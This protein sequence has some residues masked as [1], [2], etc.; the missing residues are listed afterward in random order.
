MRITRIEGIDVALP[1]AAPLLTC[2]G[3]LAVYPRTLVLVHTD[4]ELVGIG[5]T[6]GLVGAEQIAAFGRML[7]GFDPWELGLVRARIEG[8]GYYVT[9][10]RAMA[11]IE[12]ACLDLMGKS[13]DRPVHSL[14]GGKVRS[15]VPAAAYLFSRTANADGEGA[16]SSPEQILEQARRWGAEYGFDAFK[17]KGG[18]LTPDAD[19]ETLRLLAAELGADVTLR[20]DPQ[21]A[22]S[23]PTAM[24]V[25]RQM[26]ALPMEYLEDPVVGM[27]AMAEVRD[28][29]RLPLA[30]NMCVTRFDHLGQAV[31]LRPVD[32]IL[33]DIWYWGGVA[34]TLSLDHVA[35]HLGFGLGMHSGCESGIGLAAMLHTAA[36]MPNLKSPIDVMHLH[37]VDDVVVGLQRPTGGVYAVPDGPGLGVE[38]DW[39]KVQRYRAAPVV[40]AAAHSRREI[41]VLPAY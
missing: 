37:V 9:H 17:V 4:E 20:I 6:S 30:T 25:G 7:E 39:D 28:R 27:S 1:I 2:Y 35:G 19:V 3:A 40:G 29:V 23:P 24:R 12:I 10:E 32:V 15:T 14:L 18:V 31:A 38:L 8:T 34:K 41:P 16:I 11:G 36:V 21:G 26:E 13:I 33:S 5:E 22:W